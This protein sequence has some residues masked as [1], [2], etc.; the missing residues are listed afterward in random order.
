MG[1]SQ[2]LDRLINSNLGVGGMFSVRNT[3]D[4][5]SGKFGIGKVNSFVYLDINLA[6]QQMVNQTYWQR[7]IDV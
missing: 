3:F 6:L 5:A 4:T 7:G 1:V 2:E